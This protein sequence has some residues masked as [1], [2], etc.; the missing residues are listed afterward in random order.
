MRPGLSTRT[1]AARS[2]GTGLSRH[3]GLTLGL[4]GFAGF[5]YGFI[6]PSSYALM[7][8]L[9][10]GKRGLGTSFVSV[11]YG[12]GGLIGAVL[13]STIIAKAGWQASFFSLGV[14]GMLITALEVI[15]FK[16]P[17]RQTTQVRVSLR[18][19]VNSNISS[20]TTYTLR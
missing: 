8:D 13:A 11:S 14:I 12:T 7:S 18:R 19:A 4:L 2:P 10:P 1:W 16:S 5:G 3:Y 17:K 20:P 6:T 9:L 15:G